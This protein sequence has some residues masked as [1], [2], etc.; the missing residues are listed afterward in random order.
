[1]TGRISIMLRSSSGSLQRPSQAASSH[2]GYPPDAAAVAACG[3]LGLRRAGPLT[4]P[5]ADA[6]TRIT[7]NRYCLKLRIFYRYAGVG[8]QASESV[9]VPHRNDRQTGPR[10]L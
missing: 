3:V 9:S 2:H 5:S 10:Q 1:M 6:A 7:E 8:F 4:T